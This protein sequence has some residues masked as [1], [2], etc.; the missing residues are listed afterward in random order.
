MKNYVQDKVVVITGASSGFGK[1]TTQGILELGG[2]VIASDINV[3]GLAE[4]EKEVQSDN[5][6]TTKCDTTSQAD[7]TAMIAFAIAEFGRVDVLVNNAGIMPLAFL[8][9][10]HEAMTQWER[11]I[12]TN[13][14]GV[15][16]GITAVY[17]QMIKQGKGQIVNIS[18]IYGNGP[19]EGGTPYGMTKNAVKFMTDSLRNE[20]KG[21]IKFTTI[22]PTF[23][24]TNLLGTVINH[25][26]TR[27]L[28]SN[29]AP[30]TK[31]IMGEVMSGK[32][33]PA[34]TD[35]ENIKYFLL[36][37]QYIADNIIYTI[38]QP[39][40]V[41]ISDITIRAAGDYYTE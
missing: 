35:P 8:A 7:V 14:K 2:K 37:P 17:D 26:A 10:H 9:D 33:D 40:G 38:N 41:S 32:A 39:D 31:Q 22:K 4:L 29:R 30:E 20:T 3:A 27:G 24:A 23:C 34:Y 19:V 1:L 6:R 36:D 18:S 15:L 21:Q 28:L 11:C 13:I 25:E 16:Y 5:L 12:D